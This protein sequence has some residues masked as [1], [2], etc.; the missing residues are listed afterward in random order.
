MS[1]APELVEEG[2]RLVHRAAARG[3]AMRLLG[4]AAIWLRSSPRTRR[5]L[6]RSY[7]DLDFAAH[8]KQSREIRSVLEAEGYLPERVFNATHGSRRLL[9]HA[10]DGSYHVDVF[11]DVFEMSHTLDLEARL[12]IEEL[13]L[14]AAELLLTKL[15][16]AEVNRK[17]ISDTVMILSDHEIAGTDGPGKLNAVRVAELCAADWGLFTTVGDNLARTRDILPELLDDPDRRR[18]VT[19]R[20]QE[21]ERRLSEIPKTIGWR[22]RARVGRR[23]RWY[24]VPE[25]V[26]R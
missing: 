12:E 6:G 25:E 19:L 17:D 9:Y 16:I 11:L 15:Q 13:T 10:P 20:I 8:R 24:E 26:V 5:A 3:A 2:R 4:G 21:L 14:P 18:E 7:P 22:A 1:D 23:I